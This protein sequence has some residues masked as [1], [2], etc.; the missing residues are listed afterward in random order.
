MPRVIQDR[1]IPPLDPATRRG[2]KPPGVAT[3]LNVTDA[4]DLVAAPASLTKTFD[5]VTQLPDITIGPIAFHAATSY[6][7]H[8]SVATQLAP[9]LHERLLAVPGCTSRPHQ[10][11]VHG[12]AAQRSIRLRCT[13]P[14]LTLITSLLLLGQTEDY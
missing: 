4:G 13:S 8:P 3:W 9:Y 11:S 2:A 10:I 14:E 6:L 5:G 1:L 7:S 12:T